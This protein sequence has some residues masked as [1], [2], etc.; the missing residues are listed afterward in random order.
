MS[1]CVHTKH[2]ALAEFLQYRIILFSQ[3]DSHRLF[4]LREGLYQCVCNLRTGNDETL[5]FLRSVFFTLINIVY[6]KM[7]IILPERLEVVQTQG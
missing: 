6:T 4:L 3:W 1:R 2:I 5:A 7:N